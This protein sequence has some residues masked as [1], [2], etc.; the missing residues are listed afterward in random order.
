VLVLDEPTNDLDIDTLELLEDLLQNYE[1]TVFLVSHDRAFM[2]NVATSTLAFEGNGVWRE[3]EGGVQD[4][5]VQSARMRN[6]QSST[7]PG[8]TTPLAGA[9]NAPTLTTVAP[10]AAG[11][12]LRVKDQRHL[13]GLLHAIETLEREQTALRVELADSGLYLRDPDRARHLFTRDALIEEELASAM[14]QWDTLSRT[15]DVA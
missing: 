5:L 9:K 2:D 15:L 8:T 3:F 1:G 14:D 11:A 10:T 12:K 13:D 4:W 7:R 6:M